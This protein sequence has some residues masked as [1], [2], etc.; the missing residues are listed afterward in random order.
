MFV[1]FKDI[2]F[3]GERRTPSARHSNPPAYISTSLSELQ[4][5]EHTI[6]AVY[7]GD[8]FFW[9]NETVLSER[10]YVLV[11]FIEPFLLTAYRIR[12]G[13]SLHL[14]DRMPVG[15]SLSVKPHRTGSARALGTVSSDGFIEI[16][17]L[18][19]PGDLTGRIDSTRYGAISQL[20]LNFA[21]SSR[22]TRLL[23]SE[24]GL[25]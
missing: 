7:A 2:S 3:V 9:A 6:Q 1:L 23:I 11:Q 13:N 5:G 21:R 25:Y 10:D 15:S 14:F 19:R 4:I 22:P 16:Q 18:K 12:S 8:T 17:R 24:L 20:R